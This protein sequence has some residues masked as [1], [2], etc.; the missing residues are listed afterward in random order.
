MLTYCYNVR[1]LAAG[2][3]MLALTHMG[4]QSPRTPDPDGHL[5]GNIV[6]RLQPQRATTQIHV[7]ADTPVAFEIKHV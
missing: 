7:T 4:P 1:V 5:L 6:V 3:Y 2:R